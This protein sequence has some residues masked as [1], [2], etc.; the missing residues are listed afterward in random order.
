M[1]GEPFSFRY[2]SFQKG[3]HKTPEFQTLSR[4]GQVPVLLEN[5]CVRV[6]AT[7]I[8]E[9]LAEA[10]GL[11]QGTGLATCQAVREWLYWEVDVLF[12]PIFNCHG[13]QL[14]KPKLL[15]ISV[16][17]L[18]ADYHE[19]RAVAALMVRAVDLDQLAECSRRWRGCWMR[20]RS[21]RAATRPAASSRV[22]SLAKHARH[23]ARPASR[24]PTSDQSPRSTPGPARWHDHARCQAG[25]CSTADHA[26]GLQSQADRQRGIASTTAVS[27]QQPMGLPQGDPHQIG[28]TQPNSSWLKMAAASRVTN[29]STDS[30]FLL[31]ELPRKQFGSPTFPASSRGHT[32]CL[33]SMSIGFRYNNRVALGVNDGE[34]AEHLAKGASALVA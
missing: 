11:F 18:I 32:R 30:G 27:L 24:R 2:V 10:L 9:H 12:P 28:R 13:I 29:M 7:A 5:G 6:Q 17:P 3:A 16:E 22:T 31:R 20:L 33:S 8:V 4:W 26:A 1:S 23:G 15:P 21:A 14:G 34:R 25:D 19:R